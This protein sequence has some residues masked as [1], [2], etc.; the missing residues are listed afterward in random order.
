MNNL[1]LI[2]GEMNAFI[3]LLAIHWQSD[4]L[5]ASYT[6]GKRHTRQETHCSVTGDPLPK[7]RRHCCPRTGTHCPIIGDTLPEGEKENAARWWPTSGRELN[8]SNHGTR[9]NRSC[10]LNSF[11]NL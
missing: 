1:Q 8:N 4:T 11:A 9:Y 6:D 3:F 10:F 2:T 5:P 7:D